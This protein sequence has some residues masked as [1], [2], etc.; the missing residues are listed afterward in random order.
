MDFG[1]QITINFYFVNIHKT[2]VEVKT[3]KMVVN[4]DILDQCVNHATINNFIIERQHLLAII[5]HKKYI[6]FNLFY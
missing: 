4:L 5:V 3:L 6:I 1:F 2:I